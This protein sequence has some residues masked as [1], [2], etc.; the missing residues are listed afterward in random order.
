LD[1]W[2]RNEKRFGEVKVEFFVANTNGS[3]PR[4]IELNVKYGIFSTRENDDC[5]DLSF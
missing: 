3:C 5:E 4:K 1:R 2:V